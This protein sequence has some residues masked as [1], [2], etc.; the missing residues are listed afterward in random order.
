MLKLR[1]ETNNNTFT[2]FS[3]EA[4]CIYCLK[5]VIK[6][7]YENEK[8]GTIHDSMGNTVGEFSLTNW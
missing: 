4:E 6:K 8:K 3:K 1:V 7:I 2:D 5:R